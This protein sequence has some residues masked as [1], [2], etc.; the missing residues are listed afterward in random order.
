MKRTQ[1]YVVTYV[2][3]RYE[4]LRKKFGYKEYNLSEYNN[5]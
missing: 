2:K 5:G 4:K 1:Y 3:G